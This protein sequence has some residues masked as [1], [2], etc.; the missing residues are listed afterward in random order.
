[1]ANKAAFLCLSLLLALISSP[2]AFAAQERLN[3]TQL[4]GILGADSRVLVNGAKPPWQAIGQIRT[5]DVFACS[6]ILISPQHVLTAAHCIWNKTSNKVMPVESLR[7][8]TGYHREQ[9]IAQRA[10]KHIQYSK[11]YQFEQGPK[12]SLHNLALDWAVLTLEQPINTIQAIPLSSLSPQALKA[13]GQLNSFT[14][15]GYSGDRR[16]I[17]TANKHCEI[18]GLYPKQPLIAHNCDATK[19]DSGS[20]LL[21]KVKGQFQ[22]F[23]LL[24]G[25]QSFANG[26]SQGIA[27]AAPAIPFTAK[28]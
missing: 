2:P 18:I 3:S 24:I 25:V 8:E 6:G 23:A 11:L 7:F 10:V 19:G 13:S 14:Q 28:P 12:M 17:L 16:Y 21:I 4:V 27:I 22:V 1:M 15:A 26:T 5:A 9:F 20:P